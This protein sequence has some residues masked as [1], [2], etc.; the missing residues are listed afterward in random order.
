MGVV[1]VC[2]AGRQ[3]A[4]QR[5]V[6]PT[7]VCDLRLFV[8]GAG[9]EYSLGDID[10]CF[11]AQA[12]LSTVWLGLLYQRGMPLPWAL[13]YMALS[14]IV[15]G[16]LRGALATAMHIPMTVLSFI[17]AAILSNLYP[18]N[19]V[20]LMDVWGNRPHT[21]AVWVVMAGVFCCVPSGCNAFGNT[22]TGEN[23]ALP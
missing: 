10:L 7:S 9:L 1:S 5:C 6:Y 17:L 19:D 20:I 13:L 18:E 2:A 16:V 11:M 21:T 23:T 22:P 14:Q 8:L 3:D 15:M 4:G 12:S